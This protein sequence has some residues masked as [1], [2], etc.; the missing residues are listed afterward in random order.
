MSTSKNNTELLVMNEPQTSHP[1]R[2]W[3]ERNSILFYCYSFKET[4]SCSSDKLCGNFGR[5]VYFYKI[6]ENGI[7]GDTAQFPVGVDDNCSTLLHLLYCFRQIPTEETMTMM[8][9]FFSNSNARAFLLYGTAPS[10][11]DFGQFSHNLEF[12]IYSTP[13]FLEWL[14]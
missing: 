6:E 11:D 3:K 1:S 13:T 10:W 5:K 8:M 7:I 14:P 12:Y 9:M 2:Q 4:Y